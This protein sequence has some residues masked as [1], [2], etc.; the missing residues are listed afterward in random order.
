MDAKQGG[1]RLP[2]LS[3]QAASMTSLLQLWLN[4]AGLR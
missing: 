4:A 1:E 3:L 2:I